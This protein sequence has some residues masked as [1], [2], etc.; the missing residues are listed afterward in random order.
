MA[1][2]TYRCAQC[3]CFDIVQPM[4][5]VRPTHVCPDCGVEAKRVYSAPG[6]A[7][8]PRGLHRVADAAAAS[9]DEPQ[10]VQAIPKGSPRPHQPRWSPFTG[11]KPINA[12]R[13]PAGPYPSLPR[14]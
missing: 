13:R 8:M 5:S 12:S 10:V 6:L 2:Y 14:L 11:A 1:T 4:S 9:A 3:D 7:T